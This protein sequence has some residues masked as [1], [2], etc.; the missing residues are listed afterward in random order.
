MCPSLF[1]LELD[2][3]PLHPCF[4]FLWDAWM[5]APMYFVALSHCFLCSGGNLGDSS[6]L[7]PELCAGCCSSP[8]VLCW[9]VMSLPPWHCP[10]AEPWSLV[11][12]LSTLVRV[13]N[14]PPPAATIELCAGYHRALYT[15]FQLLRHPELWLWLSGPALQTLKLS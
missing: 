9:L 3:H 4:G 2:L 5:A 6:Q 10:L 15:C 1:F 11:G 7:L 14:I 12:C 13:G 8:R